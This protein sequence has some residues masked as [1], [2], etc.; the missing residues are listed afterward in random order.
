VAGVGI[1]LVVHL[2][3]FAF[4]HA[5]PAVPVFPPEATSSMTIMIRQAAPRLPV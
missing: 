5:G 4:R 3:L 1:S 2:L